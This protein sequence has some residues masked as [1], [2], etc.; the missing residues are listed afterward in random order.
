MR[1]VLA[2]FEE[3]V[4]SRGMPTWRP[5]GMLDGD[6]FIDLR[7]RGSTN[8]YALMVTSR[9]ASD[10]LPR[11]VDVAERIDDIL[12]NGVKRRMAQ[13]LGAD[14][15]DRTTLAELI[16]AIM[17]T[18]PPGKWGRIQSTSEGNLTVTLGDWSFTMPTVTNFFGEESFNKADSTTLGPVFTYIEGTGSDW[19]VIGN[20]ATV[21]GVS[22]LFVTRC[23]QNL[24]SQNHW[25][26]VLVTNGGDTVGPMV[27]VETTTEADT[28]YIFEL[29]DSN[30]TYYFWK[31]INGASTYFRDNITIPAGYVNTVPMRLRVEVDGS[32]VSCYIN[33]KLLHTVTD[34]SIVTNDHVGII[35]WNSNNNVRIDAFTFGDMTAPTR[36][37]RLEEDFDSAPLDGTKWTWTGNPLRSATVN[38]QQELELHN[39]YDAGLQAD[40]R[41]MVESFVG[42]KVT[43]PPSNVWTSSSEDFLKVYMDSYNEAALAHTGTSLLCRVKTGG[44]FDDTYVSG[45]YDYTQHLWRRIR[46]SGTSFYFDTSP[47]GINWT[48]RSVKSTT[49]WKPGNVALVIQTGDYGA[50]PASG[51]KVL[52]DKVNIYPEVYASDLDW[53]V[54]ANDYSTVKKDRSIDN[55]P[56][57]LGGVIYAKGIGVHNADLSMPVPSK[58]SAFT[59]KIGIDDEVGVNAH[60]GQVFEVWNADKTVRLYQSAQ[61]TKAMSPVSIS[62]SVVGLTTIRLVTTAGA[63][64]NTT[65]DHGDWADAKF[66]LSRNVFSTGSIAMTGKVVR[67]ARRAVLGSIA[68]TGAASMARVVVAAFTGAI[69]ATGTLIRKKVPLWTASI[70]PAGTYSK[71]AT[72][73]P[74]GS[75]TSVGVIK[76]SPRKAVVGSVTAVGSTAIDYLGRAVGRIGRAI[77]SVKQPGLALLRVRRR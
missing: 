64:L 15:P 66:V 5:L 39:N 72:K 35:A 21:N 23:Q 59:A 68:V 33:N 61:I 70:M 10:S 24:S 46:H 25:S 71:R 9:P 40:R 3:A 44:A 73:R 58:A 76:R 54:L 52:I 18:P 42:A 7:D 37:S 19:S 13:S 53:S 6:D 12:D 20:A 31:R 67:Q 38:G 1:Y 49:E 60:D 41:N 28:A 74:V 51:R 16:P 22:Q 14:L 26:E 69:I 8:G 50:S 45:G 27:R 17:F 32:T 55:A 56:L 4:D 30:N 63:A 34:T 77:M 75:V 48:S 2:P 62:V 11:Q 65:Y 43:S 47:D 36:M 57:S 29:R